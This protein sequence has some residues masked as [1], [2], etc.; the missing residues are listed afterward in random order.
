MW[1]FFCNKMFILYKTTTSIHFT[2]SQNVKV[3]KNK[4]RYRSKVSREVTLLSLYVLDSN[5]VVTSQCR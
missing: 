4:N 1:V 3:K 5:M 2:I